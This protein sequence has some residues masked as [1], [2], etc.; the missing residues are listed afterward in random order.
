MQI[1]QE[2]LSVHVGHVG[3]ADN[4]GAVAEALILA[5]RKVCGTRYTCRV[6]AGRM[7]TY[8]LD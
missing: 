7:R 5:A 6:G 2:Q 4:A 8:L 1:T 3:N